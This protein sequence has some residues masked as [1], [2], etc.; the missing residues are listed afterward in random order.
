M[1][2]IVAAVG[3]GAMLLV[4]GCTDKPAGTGMPTAEPSSAKLS[5]EQLW[6]PCSLPDSVVAATGADPG[7]E[8]TT[9]AVVERPDWRLCQW[10]APPGSDGRWGYYVLGSS[11]NKTLD[12]FRSNTYFHDF[13]DVEVKGRPALRFLLGSWGNECEFAFE[14]SQGVVSVNANKYIDSKSATDPCVL[15]LAAAE[16]IVDV[17]PR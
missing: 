7:T 2:A 1:R 9:P 3:V 12:E 10:T 6:D 15:A 8:N 13:S 11:T 5:K 14:T 4:V 17:I 16:Q